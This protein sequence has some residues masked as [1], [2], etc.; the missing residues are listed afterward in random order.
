MDIPTDAVRLRLYVGEDKRHGDRTL[1]EAIALKARDL[2][3]AGVTVV[4]G[5]LGFGR[6]T[7]LHTAKVLFSEDLP[8]TIEIIDAESKINAFLDLL[9]DVPDIGLV[10]LERVTVIR[11]GG[12]PTGGGATS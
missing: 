6:S 11:G 7:R 10:T 8:M 2:R 9:Q 4:R 3:L 12:A 1:Y 5:T